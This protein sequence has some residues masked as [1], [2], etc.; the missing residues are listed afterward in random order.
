V[1]FSE[2]TIESVGPAPFCGART[3]NGVEGVLITVSLEAPADHLYLASPSFNSLRRATGSRPCTRERS[4]QR[5]RRGHTQESSSRRY[6]RPAC[7]RRRHLL[8]CRLERRLRCVL[9]PRP[10]TSQQGIDPKGAFMPSTIDFVRHQVAD[11]DAWTK[12]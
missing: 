1:T 5:H 8:P 7:G 12:V 9:L 2:T 10:V 11:F 6:R 3:V 4:E